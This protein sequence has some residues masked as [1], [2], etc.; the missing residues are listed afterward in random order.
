MGLS[1]GGSARFQGQRVA[2]SARVEGV[3]G[4]K[5]KAGAFN[6][7]RLRVAYTTE[8]GGTDLKEIFLV[9][10]LGVV[11]YRTQEAWVE[12]LQRP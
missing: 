10:G 5:V 3:E 12:L 2:L 6:A 7:Y 4:V 1:W 8:K 9:P 11:A